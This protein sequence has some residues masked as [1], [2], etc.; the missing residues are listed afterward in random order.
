[1]DLSYEFP[2]QP[3]AFFAGR[4]FDTARDI[5]GIRRYLFDRFFDILG[6]KPSGK[7][8]RLSQRL[9]V[10]DEIPIKGFSGP[11]GQVFIKGIKKKTV[12]LI[13]FEARRVEFI[14]YPEGLDHFITF[15]REP[16]AK[17]RR[18]IAVKL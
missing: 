1:M 10:F 3:L 15:A 6:M 17:I 13:I 8:D 11:A 2:H 5:D 4:L 16:S 9:N 18:F 7:N 14:T 12:D